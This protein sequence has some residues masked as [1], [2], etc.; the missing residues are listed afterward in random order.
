MN[1]RYILCLKVKL[2]SLLRYPK[3]YTTLLINK[4]YIHSGYSCED[5]FRE[6]DTFLHSWEVLLEVMMSPMW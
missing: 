6:P 1:Y 4:I 3:C 5:H 2:N